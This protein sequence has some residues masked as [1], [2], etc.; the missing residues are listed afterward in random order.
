MQ[1]GNRLGFHQFGSSGLADLIREQSE[2]LV[3]HIHGHVHDGAFM[4]YVRGP[5]GFP[6]VNPG[7]LS[8]GEYGTLTLIKD[9]ENGQWRVFE[10][11]KKYLR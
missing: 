1:P 7:S 3:V 11:T 2:S 9:A 5:N 10:A 8:F 6:I 4:D